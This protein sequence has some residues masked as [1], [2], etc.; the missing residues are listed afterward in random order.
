SASGTNAHVIIEAPAPQDAAGSA[1]TA[2]E[3]DGPPRAV[4]LLLT[5][6][7]AAALAGN[8]RRVAALAA[9]GADRPRAL[10]VAFSL[11]TGRTAFEHRAVVVGTDGDEL[12]RSLEAA[13]AAVEGDGAGAGPLA[14]SVVRGVAPEGGPGTTV[15]VFPGQGPQWTGMAVELMETA[16]VFAASMRECAQALDPY[17]D[18]PLLESLHDEALLERV[19]SVQPALFAVMVSLA[20]L[21]RSFGV[22]PA[23]VVG[24]S[25]GEIAAAHVAGALGLADAARLVAVR[26]RLIGRRLSGSGGMLSVARPR[27]EVEPWLER[28][29]DLLAVGAVNSPGTT[30]VSGDSD[31]LRELTALCAEHGVRTVVVPI[32]YPSHAP[33]VEAVREEFLE[34]FAQLRPLPAKVPFYSTVE[35]DWVEGTSLDAAYWY[36]NLRTPVRFADAVTGLAAQDHAAFLEV[37]P[38]AVLTTTVQETLA[39]AGSDALATGT[40][41]RG[42][43]GM[44]RF[45]LSAGELWSRGVPVRWDAALTGGRTVPLPS[46]AFQRRR[47]WAMP[48][49]RPADAAALGLSDLRHP[50]LAASL[51]PAGRDELLLTGQLTPRVQPWL[52]DHAVDGAVLLPASAFLELA[53]RAG[54]EAGCPVVE[55]LVLAAPLVLSGHAPVRVQVTVA[56]PDEAGRRALSVHAAHGGGDAPW[57]LC[58]TG[59]LTPEGGAAPPSADLTRWPPRDAVPIDVEDH[60]ALLVAAGYRYGPAFQ[61]L[62]A[63]WRRGAETFAEVELP[64]AE[65]A[66]AG[67]YGL[68]PALLD[69]ALHAWGAGQGPVRL[70]FRWSGVRLHAAGATALRVRLAPE[71]PDTVALTAADGEG[72]PVISVTALEVR[73]AAAAVPAASL[74]GLYTVQWSPL[75]VPSGDAPQ[76]ERLVVETGAAAVRPGG[77]AALSDPRPG[78]AESAAAAA[79]TATAQ[80]L[81]RLREVTAAPAAPP[82]PPLAV[83][84]SGAVRTGP[85]DA[86]PDPAGAAV[87]GLVRSAQAEHPERFAL[88]DVDGDPASAGAVDAA[89]AT[90][91]PQVAVRGGRVLVPRL[92]RAASGAG[93]PVPQAP[94]WSLT[95]RP[96]GTLENLALTPDAEATAPL[97]EGEVRVAVR[98]AGLNFRDT[99]VALGMYPD[100]EAYLGGEGAGV[101]TQTG[102][103]VTGLA[104]GDRVTGVLR[105]AFGPVAVADARM[106][107][108]FPDSWSF[109]TAASVPVAFLTAYY[110]LR[111]VADLKAGQAVLIH[112]GAG[113]VGSA[114]VQLARHWGAEVYATASAGKQHLLRAAGLDDRHIADSRSTGFEAA[115]AEA[116][117]GR[118]VDV[119]LNSLAGEFVDASLRLLPRGGCFAEMGKTDP[120][121]PEQVAAEHPGVAYRAFDL[122]EAAGPDRVGEMLAEVVDLLDR[123]LLVPPPL[124]AWDV[125]RA[126]EAFRLLGQGALAGKAVLTL[127]RPIGPAGTVLVTGGTTGIGAHVARHLVAAHGV[128]DLL[129]VSRS[130]PRAR[131]A[132]ALLDELRAAGARA[133]AVACDA[134]DREALRAVVAAADPPVTAVVHSAGVLADGTLDS[135]GGD[136]LAAALRPKADA[137]A[138]LHD[139]T[140]GLDLS[141]FVLFSSA[142]GVLGSPGQAGY[143]AANAFLDAFAEQR[144]A[145]GLPAVAV[146]WGLWQEAGGMTAGLDAADRQRMTRNGVLGLTTERGLRLLDA[147]AGFGRPAVVAAAL[148]VGGLRRRGERTPALLRTLVGRTR[149]AAGQGSVPGGRSLPQRLAALPGAERDRV[150]LGAVRDHAATVLGHSGRE[151]IDADRPFKDLGFDSLTAVELR[152]RLNAAGSLHLPVTIVF[153]SG[154]ARELAALMHRELFP[155]PEP[156]PEPDGGAAGGPARGGPV[157][158]PG[159][160]GA[161]AADGDSAPVQA[162]GGLDD[163]GADD[164]IARAFQAAG[165]ASPAARATRTDD[166]DQP[167]EGTD[168]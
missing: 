150:L 27:A 106:V 56:E 163:M 81:A 7:T 96:P 136:D 66:S 99:L 78:A 36:R 2:A 146:A 95:A 107:A 101:V 162:A 103:G 153:E 79:R 72:N 55:E 160:G 108:R 61:G 64:E 75:P 53:V 135:L 159:T 24:A 74:D 145:A 46:Y 137:V 17:L 167:A 123:G 54:D 32:D 30:V 92:A 44:D 128:R 52:A 161:A 48:A 49:R 132:A 119:V 122:V 100:P 11:A 80:V 116:T 127:P 69:A 35:A 125:S 12:W 124:H 37:A 45:L 14:A 130:G 118:G 143:A 91:E 5:G 85:D 26:A 77:A 105:R 60:Y 89:V 126:P 1:A 129:L 3:P 98:A 140:S 164:L 42:K 10:D 28:W 65:R 158:A 134:A 90:G 83:V 33:Q 34:L 76:A 148:D 38:H 110:G 19:E 94:A 168:D 112:A 70:P 82:G 151:L 147:A 40:L 50:L 109:A 141:A 115:F 15:F 120:R 86:P 117:G 25:Q 22:E 121:R 18:V 73:E 149:A 166:L 58:A 84:T 93:L 142:A 102:P 133:V 155:E 21:W 9:A 156:E 8:A 57:A 59:V 13:A 41:R 67:G 138:A 68:H 63:A 131:G 154:S 71:G 97:A 31:A 152:N 29:P 4:P 87:W 104:P 113:G 165:A 144:A 39:V 20:A 43:G 139:A 157:P 88:V 51:A 114:A 23:A 111:D 6:R 62:R 47:Y 16:P